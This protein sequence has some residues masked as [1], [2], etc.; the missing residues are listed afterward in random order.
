MPNLHPD[1]APVVI[2]KAFWKTKW[3]YSLC[4]VVLLAGVSAGVWFG[5]VQPRRGTT[6][7]DAFDKIVLPADTASATF[8]V[9]ATKKDRLGVDPKT[10]F[11]LTTTAPIAAKDLEASISFS[12][13]VEFAIAS[14]DEKT[15]EITPKKPLGDEAVYTLAVNATVQGTAGNEKQTYQ[16]AF[17]PKTSLAIEGTLPRDEATGVPVNTGIEVTF[18]TDAVKDFGQHFTITPSAKGAFEQHGRTW[19]FVPAEKLKAATLYTV[20]LAAALP[21]QGSDVT[22]GQAFSFQFETAV[23]Q[24][25]N[26]AFTYARFSR[27]FQSVL[28]KEAP[29]LDFGYYGNLGTPKATVHRFASSQ[30]MIEKLHVL[31][32]IPT[33]ATAALDT[34]LIST[35]GL[36][37]IGTYDAKVESFDNQYVL[38]LPSGFDAGYYLMT[39]DV[40]GRKLQTVIVV[41]ELGA[42]QFVS[43][44]DTVL[45]L[46]DLK[47]GTPLQKVSAV[48][49]LDG[50]TYSS[51]SE[52]VVRLTTPDQAVDTETDF[53]RSY[54]TV[55]TSDNRE[56][57]IPFTP[58]G[59]SFFAWRGMRDRPTHDTYWKY[60]YLDRTLY[61]PSD[62]VNI[63]GIIQPR[64]NPKAEEYVV[65]VWT[66]NVTDWNGA[67]LPL[68]ED[69]VQTNASG[70]FT[71][72][73]ALT[74]L[75]PGTYTLSIE[76]LTGKEIA[77][78]QFE[79]QTFTKPA[80]GVSL[81]PQRQ[82]G[83]V[84]EQLPIQA[85]ATF[86]DGTPT[87]NAKLRYSSWG[88]PGGE[89]TD[90]TANSQGTASFNLPL[91]NTNNSVGTQ[92]VTVF[93][94][95]ASDGDVQGSADIV[96]FPSR[97]ISNLET[98]RNGSQATLKLHVRNVDVTKP[99]TDWW[100][101]YDTMT[102]GPA[103]NAKVEVKVIEQVLTKT[104]RG[105]RYDFIEKQTVDVYDY[106]YNDV[107][108]T[109]LTGVTDAQGAY[110]KDITL[111]GTSSRVEVRAFDTKNLAYLQTA[112]FGST[113]YA[114][115]ESAS[116]RVVD[117][118]QDGRTDA[119]LVYP[120]G[121]TT[122]LEFRKGN[123]A[124][125]AKGTFMFVTLQNGIQDVTITD[126]P[127]LPFTYTEANIPN[128]FVTGVWFTGSAFRAPAQYEQAMLQ[129]DAE[130]RALQLELKAEKASYGPGDTVRVTVTAK[131]AAGKPVDARVNLSA[132][133]EALNV[134][135][136]D[137]T[138]APLA[139]LYEPTMSGLLQQY[140]SHDTARLDAMAEGGGGTGGDR[141]DFK[142]AVLFQEVQT[143]GDGQAEV[144]FKVP[145]NL[146][147]WR[148]T[149][150]GITDEKLA[151][152]TSLGV[153]VSKPVFALLTMPDEFVSQDKP[154]IIGRAY[155]TGLTATDDV[156]FTLETPGLGANQTR[157]GKAFAAQK[158][159]LP[160]LVAGEQEVKLTV[161]KGNQKDT[162]IRKITVVDSRLS[163]QA[164]AWLT[165]AP[166]LTITGSP[167]GRTMVGV[168]DLGRGRII[169]NLRMLQWGWG[170][171]LERNLAGAIASDA[172]EK[173]QPDLVYENSG[174][175][176][177]AYQQEDG[178]ISEVI[179]GSSDVRLSAL[180]AAQAKMFDAVRLRQ[181][182]LG[183]LNQKDITGE[184]ASFALYGLANLG[185]PV[186]AELD[187]FVATSGIT[188]EEKLTAAL[189]Y[190]ALGASQQA[191]TI[192][193]GLLET[194]GETQAPYIR[195]KLGNDDDARIVNTARFSILAEGLKL[196][197]RVGIDTYL[198]EKF[199]KDYPTNLE[200]ALGMVAAIP[201]LDNT[202]VSVTYTAGGEPKTLATKDDQVTYVSLTT[203]EATQFK[204][205]KVDGPA[206]LIVQT[207]Q[208]F[209]PNTAPHDTRLGV[210]RKF[211]RV[212]DS[213]P[214][215]QGDIVRVDIGLQVGKGIVDTDFTVTDYLP[216]GLAAL[217]NPWTRNVQTSVGFNY[218]TEIA[219]Q[220]L[221]F[222]TWGQKSFYY[223]ARVV[224][225]GSY[226][227]EPAVA[228]G[229]KSRDVINYSGGQTLGIE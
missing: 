114:D 138:P 219:G 3:F 30:E 101:A 109:T 69:R 211:T 84:G 191:R 168:T 42:A 170:N 190:Q 24:Q 54:F 23:A 110:T 174:F 226:A 182:L 150:Q 22:L 134:I 119:Q 157:T 15:F 91:A 31:D 180:A 55:K 141:K 8:V 209:D 214:L 179:W 33:W 227:A 99:V 121:G 216:S 166:D 224:N 213:G 97:V 62:T 36:T 133:D 16:W 167:S 7:G 46:Q 11:V 58:E 115:A 26:D 221:T 187:A 129:F 21:V 177:T 165:V 197:Q 158:F 198:A 10:S 35:E 164:T 218:P 154:T 199:P 188:D 126:K 14:T 4:G 89:G 103:A 189:A 81:S 123:T 105:T 120:L 27:S 144:T 32:D 127:Q 49:A 2:S 118:A 172:L 192:A 184:Q 112:Y 136:M 104:K 220:R 139:G 155:G 152:F 169:A 137:N 215:K 186:L 111:P 6:G 50:K 41:S 207:V 229:Q 183:K 90:I 222:N 48:F 130:T 68:V 122:T 203:Q 132:I 39:L 116:Y 217:P 9:E 59:E 185:E 52:G 93:P 204:V 74:Q 61:R 66:W 92:R 75:N 12:P 85:F 95:E 156:Q 145:D 51:D 223:Y 83:I 64:K 117:V 160:T 38:R 125:E 57:V 94:A 70:T 210:T 98:D 147:S 19:V 162:L 124:V 148:V 176:P 18:S 78:K 73:L 194:Y 86:F 201:L 63:W 71:K 175:N 82:A 171:R 13:K 205:T 153:P 44:T 87:P 202:N 206:G 131:D 195:L 67:Y 146:T 60:L 196:S 96:V 181:Y 178:G 135:Q 88:Q 20:T 151:G 102:S 107:V 163:R 43:R 5:I 80:F 128:V 100:N 228:Q 143:G 29:V 225:P 142:D 140:V 65:K 72:A 159:V 212:G 28:P 1:Q 56:T 53:T 161:Q 40:K 200:R 76:T 79:V 108:R 149:A 47:A 193:M 106:R 208:P 113:Q 45:W 25:S 37:E 77:S 34:A 17:Q 173:L